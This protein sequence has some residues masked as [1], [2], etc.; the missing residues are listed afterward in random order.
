M[1]RAPPRLFS[2]WKAPWDGETEAGL[3]QIL[4]RTLK[5]GDYHADVMVVDPCHLWSMVDAGIDAGEFL[6]YD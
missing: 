3:E 1:Y 6:T 2:L 4:I 5:D